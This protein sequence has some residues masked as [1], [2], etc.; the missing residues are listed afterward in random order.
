IRREGAQYGIQIKP[1]GPRR[2]ALA[3]ACWGPIEPAKEINAESCC[4]GSNTSNTQRLEY[5]RQGQCSSLS[6]SDDESHTSSQTSK[7]VQTPK[8]MIISDYLCSGII[9]DYSKRPYQPR[10]VKLNVLMRNDGLNLCDCRIDDDLIFDDLKRLCN[11]IRSFYSPFRR[12]NGK[13]LS[14][15]SRK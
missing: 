6:S 15:A 1:S 12:I 10:T 14:P 5:P 2:P 11:S 8:H 7:T 3:D 4:M 13:C 9:R